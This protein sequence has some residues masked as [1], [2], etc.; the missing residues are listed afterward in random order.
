MFPLIEE[1]IHLNVLFD[2]MFYLCLKL[3]NKKLFFLYIILFLPGPAKQN[4]PNS[5]FLHENIAS[6]KFPSL[7]DI[8]GVNEV[9]SFKLGDSIIFTLFIL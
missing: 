1:M 6:I 9:F 4:I 7:S 3:K 5:K 2:Q 8:I